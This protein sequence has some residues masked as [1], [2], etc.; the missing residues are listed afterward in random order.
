MRSLQ[1]SRA[2]TRRTQ[3]TNGLAPA[4]WPQPT[5]HVRVKSRRYSLYIPRAIR[6]I[7]SHVR[8]LRDE[9]VSEPHVLGEGQQP[10]EVTPGGGDAT[11]PLADPVGADPQEPSQRP[12]TQTTYLHELIQPFPKVPGEA[13]AARPMGLLLNR[14]GA[15]P[16]D[17]REG[18]V[19][20]RQGQALLP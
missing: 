11:P 4:L 14:H 3:T 16:P 15:T 7:P 2:G 8:V 6:Y 10:E 20:H 9:N 17:L 5:P 19:E 12:W 18:R 13:I 1:S